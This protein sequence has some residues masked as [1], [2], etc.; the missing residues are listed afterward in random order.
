MIFL[1]DLCDISKYKRNREQFANYNNQFMYLKKI[2]NHF[3]KYRDQFTKFEKK[4]N[5]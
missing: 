3:E 2:S 4:A 5:V 1:K